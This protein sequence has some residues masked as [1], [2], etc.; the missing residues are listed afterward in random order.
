MPLKT[1]YERLNPIQRLGEPLEHTHYW[2]EVT[3]EEFGKEFASMFRDE[4]GT[5]NVRG[6]WD[7]FR[8][9]AEPPEIRVNSSRIIVH[10]R[11]AIY[12]DFMIELGN[13]PR[14]YLHNYGFWS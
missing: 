12:D 5:E 10:Q 9:R 8:D 3:A 6:F 11:S 13:T 1:P 4:Q 14:F 7:P 2:K